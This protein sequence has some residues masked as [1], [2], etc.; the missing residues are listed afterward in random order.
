MRIPAQV[1]SVTLAV[2]LVAC[3]TPRPI[4]RAGD[5]VL[6]PLSDVPDPGA[7]QISQE[8]FDRA[9][10][11]SI[12]AIIATHG[13]GRLN[14]PIASHGRE[15]GDEALVRCLAECRNEDEF[16]AALAQSGPVAPEHLEVALA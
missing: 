8:E 1:L 6:I 7:I 10:Q 15:A 5:D 3:S 4:V 13:R 11:A 12:K 2:A 9:M 14:S 16:A